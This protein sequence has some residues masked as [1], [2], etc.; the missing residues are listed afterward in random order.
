MSDVLI[1]YFERELALLRRSAEDFKNQHSDAAQRMH[2]NEEHY[3]DPNITRLM[4]S[5]AYLSAKNEMRLDQQLPHISNAVSQALYPSFNRLLPSAVSVFFEPEVAEFKDPHRM[6]RGDRYQLTSSKG[7]PCEFQLCNDIV[8]APCVLRDVSARFAPFPFY[9]PTEH[10]A[11]AVVQLNLDACDPEVDFASIAPESLDLYANGFGQDAS[12]LIQLLLSE[13]CLITVSDPEFTQVE[14][15]DTSALDPLCVNEAFKVL[16]GEGN[17]FAAYQM[18]QEFFNYP[19][20]RKYFRLNGF[21]KACEKIK[22]QGLVLSLFFKQMPSEYVRLFDASVF[23]LH[24]SLAVNTFE[25]R[26][27]P[28]DYN[29]TRLSVPIIVDSA[30]A[31][32]DVEM[33]AV[34]KVTQ[35]RPDGEYVLKP[36]F[37]GRYF[38]PDNGLSWHTEARADKSRRL[39]HHLLVTETGPVSSLT[40]Q[41]SQY[42]LTAR[43]LCCNG[44]EPCSINPG[45]LATPLDAAELPGALKTLNIPS[46]PFYPQEGESSH[47]GLIELLSTNFTSLLHTE[48]VTEKLTQLL[49][50]FS[51]SS[52]QKALPRLI[53]KVEYKQKVSR[54][55]VDGINIFAS[56]TEIHLTLSALD[57]G[58]DLDIWLFAHLM[59][60]FFAAFCS[61]DRFVQLNVEILS[62]QGRKQLSFARHLG[63]QTCL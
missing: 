46:V 11:N 35:A 6:R 28:I 33:I 34:S 42:L 20:K 58:K 3:E 27:E 13:L 37:A 38:D 23:K 55:F 15:M 36:A 56:G 29:H 63:D 39:Q 25:S 4:E 1:R 16:P 21:A 44:K 12:G 2:L 57:E 59:N 43:L 10:S 31:Q 47:W 53:Q 22:G 14:L 49:C 52:E 48:D 62:S 5:V 45:S 17:E 9:I 50:V 41:A 24:T 19:E 26:S 54:V 18:L 61:F 60:A 32:A 8:L 40:Q 30:N 51:R 7:S